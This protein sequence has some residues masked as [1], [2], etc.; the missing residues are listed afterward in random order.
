MCMYSM[1]FGFIL[2]AFIV[3][4]I[5]SRIVSNSGRDSAVA[6][7][8]RI[9]EDAKKEAEHILREAKISAEGEILKLKEEFET[10]MRDRREELNEREHNV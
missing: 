6:E 4:M 7:A 10:E 5:M 1:Y 2:L 3:G 9:R 8:S